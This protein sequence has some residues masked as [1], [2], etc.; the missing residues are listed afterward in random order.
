MDFKQLAAK[1]GL[2]VDEYL[3][4][5]ELFIDTSAADMTN[6]EN[7]VRT[8]NAGEA[9]RAAH[10]LKGAS[11]SLGLTEIAEI[12]RLI[13]KSAREESTKDSLELLEKIKDSINSI[14]KAL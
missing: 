1:L 11:A 14:K 3:E 10:S 8:K 2:E 4:L 9:Q 6:L 13:E 7:A 5:L 12:A